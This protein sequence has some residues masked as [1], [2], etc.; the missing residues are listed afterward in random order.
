MAAISKVYLLS[1]PLEKDYFHTIY[2][3]S[4]SAQQTYFS[5]KVK[6]TYNDFTYQRKD[7]TIRIPAHVDTLYSLGVN[8]VM[9]QNPE[10][11]NK[12]F[13]A[14]IDDMQY[15]NEEVTI[16]RIK[17]D[18]IQTWMFEMQIKP[19]FVERE[20]SETDYIG[21][22]T[23]EE[24]LEV[25]DY[26]ANQKTEFT[27]GS[28]ARIV[29]GITKDS[30]GKSAQ[31]TMY[32]GIYSG[33]RYYAC[34]SNFAGVNALNEFL[35]KY[36][37][38]G[39][40]DSVQ[41]MFMAPDILVPGPDENA[42]Y[43]VAFTNTPSTIVINK[44]FERPGGGEWDQEVVYGWNTDD[45]DGYIPRNKKLMCYPY[46]YL[47]TT[48]NAG[49]A[50]PYK[51]EQFYNQSA[52]GMKTIYEPTFAIYGVLSVGCSVRMVPLKYNGV[53]VNEDE[54]I[55]LG[56]F[57]ALNWASDAYT[58][59]MTQNAVNIALDM[60]SGISQIGVGAAMAAG[61]VTTGGLTGI[62]AAGTIANGL[63]QISGTL[64]QVHQQQFAPN[65]L[66]GNINSG[67]V[68]T[69]RGKNTF[70]F[71]KMSVKREVAAIL[72]DYFDM[73]GYKCHRV[74][75]PAKAH[76]P[77]YWFTKTI[78]ANITGPI[79]QDDLQTIKNCYNSGITFWRATA[80]FKNYGTDNKPTT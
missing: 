3:P 39:V 22:H 25:G 50:V 28:D 61:A 34:R 16:V 33:M 74:K 32:D 66:K 75:I 9:Y 43:Q 62:M 30:D 46:R 4:A 78:D 52:S 77:A 26:V 71:Y 45:I 5:G 24:G 13:Y 29:I 2:F 60:A 56:K 68:T 72:D 64:A 31:G 58:N 80:D 49:T 69:A 53:A 27:Y 73:Y 42:V 36:D 35:A 67:D 23:I 20:H 37:S 7:G 19:C 79:P 59:W 57:P 44:P 63:S 55:N 65:Q 18:C 47:L 76:R 11:Y 54:G 6:K 1:V 48:N 41:C 12:W 38:E 40:G 17:T 51:F 10:Y 14:F 70:I 8:Y 15:Q 21:E